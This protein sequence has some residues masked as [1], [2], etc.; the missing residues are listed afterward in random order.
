MSRI[1]LFLAF[2]LLV[3]GCG[4]KPK[5]PPEP[6]VAVD[7]GGGGG[8]NTP[9]AKQ[10][11]D[12]DL[13]LADLK[14]T[15]REKRKQAVE[16][17]AGLAEADEGTRE[18][19]VDLLRDKST[20]GLGKTHPAQI[21]ST[22]EAAAQA[23]MKAGPK[24]ESQLAVK[25]LIPLSEGLS[26][27]D[28]AVRQ[29]TAY[30]LGQIGPAAKPLSNQLLRLASDDKE[31]RI[32]GT[33][34]NSLLGCSHSVAFAEIEAKVRGTAFDSLLLVGVADVPGLAALMNR[35]DPPDVKRRAG[36]IIAVLP[37]IPP[38]AVASLT[39]ALEDEDEVIRVL[40]A[41]GIVTA[42]EKGANKQTAA[43]LAEAIKKNF[44]AM[45][46]P[47]A[48]HPD[49]PQY[50]YFTALAKQGKLGVQ[51]A[52]ELLKHK[53][54][55]VRYL[56]LQTL[57]DIG[58]DAKEVSAQISDLFTDPD[59][60][61][62]AIVTLYRV[63]ANEEELAGGVRQLEAALAS[64]KPE[65]ILAA[66]EGVGRIGPMGKKLVPEV[67]KQLSSTVPQIRLA[68]V[69]FVGT[70]EPAEAAKQLPALSKLASDAEPL[71]RIRVGAVLE[72][73][74]PAAAPAAESVGKQLV[75]EKI[76]SVKEQF[77]DALM[78]MGPGA[79]PA[80]IGLAPLL[81][82]SSTAALLKLKVIDALVQ[83]DPASKEASAA[84]IIAA[85]DR[86]AV[87]KKAAA[88]AIGKL[89]PLPAEAQAILVRL[90]KSDKDGSVRTAAVRS[91]ATAGPR[92]KGAK[93]DLEAAANGTLP[94]AALWAKVALAAIDS[95]AGKSAG[96]VREGLTSRNGQVRLAAAEAL[97]LIGPTAADVPALLK[98][99]RESTNGASEA[100]VRALG[101]VGAGAKDAVPRLIDL[102]MTGD[103]ETRIA[104]AEALG[105]IG[106][107]SAAP[108]IP[109]LKVL[110]RG[111]PAPAPAVIKALE[112]LGAKVDG[113]PPR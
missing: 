13:W 95:D 55:R 109:K 6:D 21:N 57:G 23:L 83:A 63:G 67:L 94:G 104:A 14:G 32:R 76:D 44:P 81:S 33:A 54:Q 66:I 29:H 53:N 78:A 30:V 9:D 108:A 60:A 107:P 8:G 45:F 72:K 35:K 15:H 36:E 26:D 103:Q 42:G 68:A 3:T 85:N 48:D 11:S 90:M 50:V 34:F 28:P 46:D 110:V 47:K 112:K 62:E 113:A 75:A 96:S 20:A 37:E 84:L 17:L 97:P 99:S 87:V 80:V 4:K 69:G 61:L 39:R 52:A 7:P 88:G 25:G 100:A 56:A 102:L 59:V 19:L 111:N 10:P 24:G 71:I 16:S 49:D 5:A 74:G 41:M 2:V 77:V 93:A 43:Y 64:P 65:N 79:K 70:M 73:L 40:A 31:V 1:T 101:L 51:P 18:A 12:R 82:E 58:K 105:R 91:L 92:A 27:K 22:R 86:D 89:N 98:I 38:F 106:L